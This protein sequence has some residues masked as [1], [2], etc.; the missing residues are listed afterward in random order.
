MKKI[1]LAGPDVFYPDSAQRRAYLLQVCENYGFEGIYPG[2]NEVQPV[3]AEAI[4][5]MNLKLISEADYLIANLNPFRGFEPDSG[6]VFEMGFSLALGKTVVAYSSDLRPMIKRLQEYQALSDHQMV[7]KD[8]LMIENFSLP[9]NLMFADKVIA[10]TPEEA[11]AII[12]GM[13]S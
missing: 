10:R 8:G 13:T 5:N 9:N 4:R 6:T 11:V 12:A 2:D 1:Y 7:D 3:S